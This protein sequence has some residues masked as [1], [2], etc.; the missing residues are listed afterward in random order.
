MDNLFLGTRY[1]CFNNFLQ[2]RKIFF[3]AQQQRV[4][5]IL[6]NIAPVQVSEQQIIRR[7]AQLFTNI[8]KYI[9]TWM[10]CSCISLILCTEAALRVSCTWELMVLT[11]IA[12]CSLMILSPVDSENRRLELQEKHFCQRIVWRLTAVFICSMFV[13]KYFGA[14]RYAVCIS[15]GILLSAGLQLPCLLKRF[16]NRQ[17]GQ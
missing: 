2:K 9:Q 8:Y 3:A 11:V 17:K 14:E 1:K 4:V 5:N 7:C 13:L 16:I 10:L 15:V 6:R 12:G